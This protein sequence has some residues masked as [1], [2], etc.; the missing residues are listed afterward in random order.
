MEL[1]TRTLFDAESEV[2]DPHVLTAI[3]WCTTHDAQQSGE[4]YCWI[5][6]DFDAFPN[7]RNADCAFSTGGPDHKWWKDT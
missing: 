1:E 6:V 5:S 3:P 2:A 7:I 4:N